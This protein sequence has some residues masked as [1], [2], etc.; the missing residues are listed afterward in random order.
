VGAGEGPG[1]TLVGSYVYISQNDSVTKLKEDI[2]ESLMF[3]GGEMV[4]REGCRGG[5][6]INAVSVEGAKGIS[7]V[8]TCDIKAFYAVRVL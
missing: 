8:V 3:S 2:R 4:L 5:D 1:I 7:R 6:I